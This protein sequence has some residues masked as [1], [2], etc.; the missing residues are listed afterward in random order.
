MAAPAGQI[1]D[2]K[3]D[4]GV[5]FSQLARPSVAYP[6]GIK[7]DGVNWAGI[8]LGVA[9]WVMREIVLPFSLFK[10]IRDAAHC[11]AIG[12]QLVFQTLVNRSYQEFFI[13]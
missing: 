3:V 2:C 6:I 9:Q 5:Y 8:I 13:L 7:R 12:F 10:N 4:E 11:L 1:M